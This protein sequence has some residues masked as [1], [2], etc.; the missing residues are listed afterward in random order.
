[1]RAEFD[2]NCDWEGLPPVY[3][4]WVNDE[5]FSERTW[6]WTDKT[7]REIL[8]IQAPAGNYHVKLESV[9]PSLA[10]FR[11]SNHVIKHGEARW[12]NHKN[13]EIA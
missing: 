13:L 2:I 1:M 9:M 7:V 5:L 6:V 10:K 11:T 4:I 8:Q 3:R 12:I